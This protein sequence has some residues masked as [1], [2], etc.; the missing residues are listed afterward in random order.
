MSEHPWNKPDSPAFMQAAHMAELGVVASS[1]LHELRQPLFAIRA[2]AQLGQRAGGLDEKGLAAL[3]MQLDTVQ[4][5]IDSYSTFGATQE[6]PVLFDLNDPVRNALDMLQHRRDVAGAR[7]D[8]ALAGSF[9]PVRAR[10]TGSC[11]R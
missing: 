3:L 8:L 9:L 4:D 2:M 1:M 11:H 10:P 6:R 5:L 7:L